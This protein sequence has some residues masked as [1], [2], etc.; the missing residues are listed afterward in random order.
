MPSPKLPLIAAVLCLLAAPA[1]AQKY[2][3]YPSPQI[4]KEQWAAYGETVRQNFGDSLEVFK[5]KHLVAFADL[6]NRTFWLFTMK[7]HP[8]HPAFITRQ[9][10]EEG[11]VV[12]VRQIGYFAGK[13]EEF[14]KLFAEYLK[15]NEELK[16]DVE[17]R[18]R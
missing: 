8:A 17:R 18:N 13:E 15:R 5:D 3:P 14:A 10:Y 4:T 9:M 6:D 7:E 11:G 12:R 16:K 2:Q 1:L